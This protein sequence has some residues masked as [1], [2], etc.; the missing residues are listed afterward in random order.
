MLNFVAGYIDSMFGSFEDLKAKED[1]YA[2]KI[3]NKP[4]KWGISDSSINIDRYLY[5]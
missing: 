3:L 2:Y 5:G 1:N 4:K